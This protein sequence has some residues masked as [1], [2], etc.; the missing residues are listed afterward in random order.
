MNFSLAERLKD[1]GLTSLCKMHDI[2]KKCTYCKHGGFRATWIQYPLKVIL[3]PTENLK[4]KYTN[5][6][7]T[8]A[9][10]M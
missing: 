3:L 1:T 7:K 9:P 10:R 8:N 5:T 2:D 4:K 6:H